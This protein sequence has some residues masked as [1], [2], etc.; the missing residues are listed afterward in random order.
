MANTVSI[1][2]SLSFRA[3]SLTDQ[4]TANGTFAVTTAAPS[5]AAGAPSIPTTA[6]G[7]ALGLGSLTTPG[8]M[9]AKNLDATN[10]VDLGLVT[11]GTFY[12]FARL[13]PGEAAVLRLG[14]SAPY[15]RA[16]TAAVLL[17]YELYD[18]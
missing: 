15:A 13:L 8:W 10:Y 7:T 4:F 5:K 17:E 3:G 9:F 18:A 1:N 2:V 6:G 12:P 14:L 11:G 16:N